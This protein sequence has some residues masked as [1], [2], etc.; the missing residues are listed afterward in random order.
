MLK[1]DS[2]NA[3]DAAGKR[4]KTPQASSDE[5]SVAFQLNTD[6]SWAVQAA[7]EAEQVA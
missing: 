4:A 2:R 7:L 6:L 5:G 3:L 1:S